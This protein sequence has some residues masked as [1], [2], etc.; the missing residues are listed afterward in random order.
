[1]TNVRKPVDP[2]R[3][4]EILAQGSS[5][6]HAKVVAIV[7]EGIIFTLHPLGS[8]HKSHDEGV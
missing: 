6:S 8:I 4:H 5:K 1:M 2:R 7:T 3:Q